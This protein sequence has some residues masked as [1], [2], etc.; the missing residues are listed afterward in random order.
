MED[1]DLQKQT[2]GSGWVRVRSMPGPD[3]LS[4]AVHSSNIGG[5]LPPGKDLSQ[6]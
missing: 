4:E 2:Q 6:P 1:L 5:N 3:G